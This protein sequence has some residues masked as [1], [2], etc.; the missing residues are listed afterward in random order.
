MRK[1]VKKQQTKETQKELRFLYK[2]ELLFGFRIP[3]F[4]NSIECLDN[5]RGCLSHDG[6]CTQKVIYYTFQRLLSGTRNLW[7][8]FV[9]PLNV[10][11]QCDCIEN[12]LTHRYLVGNSN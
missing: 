3:R 9:Q 8:A 4:A 1:A 6:T 10:S 7:E 2:N 5:R 12:S 11:C